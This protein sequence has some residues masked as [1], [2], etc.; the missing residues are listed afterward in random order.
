MYVLI[1]NIVNQNVDQMKTINLYLLLICFCIL[2]LISGCSKNDEKQDMTLYD[3]P[4][5]TIKQHINGSWK[6]VSRNGGIGG[7]SYAEYENTYIKFE[8]NFYT[9]ISNNSSTKANL[10]WKQGNVLGLSTYVADIKELG[11]NTFMYS[12]VNDT[13]LISDGNY[14]GYMY[15]LIK[16]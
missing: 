11:I 8:N 7:N 6:L 9:W 12:V 2:P 10:N 16:K 3:K 15:S 4:L 1:I 14:D 5:N 13:L